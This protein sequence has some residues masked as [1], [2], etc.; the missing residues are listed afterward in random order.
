MPKGSMNKGG[1]GQ[2]PL[3]KM[4]FG[5]DVPVSASRIAEVRFQDPAD[6]QTA[7]ELDGSML[8]GAV[9][10]VRLDTSSKDASKV[11]AIGIPRS[12]ELQEVKE[13]FGQCGQVAFASVKD[14]TPVIGTVRYQTAEEASTA[15]E[16]LNGAEMEGS[17]L[18]V[19]LDAGSVKTKVQVSGLPAG[20]QWQELKD[21]F[22]QA[23]QVSHADILSNTSDTG[24]GFVGEVRY[25]DPSHAQQAVTELNGSRLGG[26]KISV[27]QDMKSQDGSKLIVKGIPPGIEWQELKDHFASIGQ[28]AFADVK[29]A[30]KGKNKAAGKGMVMV[31]PMMMMQMMMGGFGGGRY[32]AHCQRH[33]PWK[34]VA[35]VERSFRSNGNSCLCRCEGRRQSQG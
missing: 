2:P 31:D 11:I 26:G 27:T 16:I 28:V 23:G 33:P 21:F 13:F 34:R 8:S 14:D 7:L 17:T 12:A 25:D 22:G 4:A 15:V 20:T 18:E 6:A 9:I 1:F 5:V 32:K 10:S 3:K 29:G 35:G 24:A 30:G 19:K